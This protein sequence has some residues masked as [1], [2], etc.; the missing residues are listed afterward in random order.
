MIS[1]V[2]IQKAKTFTTAFGSIFLFGFLDKQFCLSV[3]RKQ[4]NYVQEFMSF[5]S[6]KRAADMSVVMCGR[7]CGSSTKARCLGPTYTLRTSIQS[8]EKKLKAVSQ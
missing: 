5:H 8:C 6:A 2:R 4:D 1:T 3:A 7:D